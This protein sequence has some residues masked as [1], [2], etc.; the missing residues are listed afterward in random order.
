MLP[1]ALQAPHLRHLALYGFVLPIGSRLLMTA[2]GLVTFCLSVSHPSTYFLPGTLL[3]WISAMPQLETLS[4]IFEFPVPN[5]DVERQL[6]QRPILTSVTLPNLRWFSFKGVSAYVEAVVHGITAPRLEKLDMEFFKQLTF[7]VPHLQQFMNTAESLRFDSAKF[8]FSGDG[9]YVKV[10]PP[11]KAAM[12]ALSMNVFCCHLDWQVS[13]VAQIS[14]SLSQIFSTVT[15]LTLEYKVYNQSSE[16]HN[17][18]DRTEWH[19]LLRSFCNVKTLHVDYGLVKELSRCLRLDNGEPPLDLL[20]ELQ[21]ITYSGSGSAGV[22]FAPF[23][24]ARQSAGRP[25]TLMFSG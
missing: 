11:E 3:Q 23:I 22:A 10:Y 13:S 15:H 21:G 4:I 14:N 6:I 24:D 1:E 17:G 19:N 2:V 20:P 16:E 12:H 18:I 25:V 5:R 7:S 9:I 8:V